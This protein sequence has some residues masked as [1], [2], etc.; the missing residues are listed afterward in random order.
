MIEVIKALCKEVGIPSTL[1]ELGVT[2]V[3]LDKLA[4]NALADACAP[5]N[6]FQPTKEEVIEMFKEFSEPVVMR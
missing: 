5:G 6:P 3:D 1:A 2:D 4:T